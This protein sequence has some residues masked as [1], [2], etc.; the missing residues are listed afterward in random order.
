M[1]PSVEAEL[2]HAAHVAVRHCGI[3]AIVDDDPHISRALAMWLALHGLGATEHTSAESLL[4]EIHQAGGRLRL[5][6]G[7]GHPR[8]LPLVGAVLDLNLSSANGFELAG[9]LLCL[10]PALP[11]VIVTALRAEER[12]RFGYPPPG[13]RYLKKPFDLAALEDAL[14]PLLH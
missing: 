14:F 7:A 2:P 11:I 9:S 13:V 10:A 12:L 6:T 4:R 5:T 8:A 3:V 1:T